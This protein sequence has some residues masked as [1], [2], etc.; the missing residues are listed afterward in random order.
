MTSLRL[1][2]VSETA[3]GMP[4]PSTTRWCLLPGLARSTGLGPLLG[5]A[6][7]PGRDWS[8]SP[9]GTSRSAWPPAASRAGARGAGPRRPPGSRLRAAASRSYPSRNPV[10][11]GGTPTGYRYA[12]RR[13]SRTGPAG[14]A[15]EAGPASASAPEPAATA[16]SATTVRPRRSTDETPSCPRN[17]PTSIQADSHTSGTSVSTSKSVPGPA[18]RP[19]PGAG[20]G[21]ALPQ[22][23]AACSGAELEIYPV[24]TLPLTNLLTRQDTVVG[25]PGAPCPRIAPRHR[26]RPRRPA[27]RR[28]RYLREPPRPGPRRQPA[29]PAPGALPAQETINGRGT[30]EGPGPAAMADAYALRVRRAAGRPESDTPTSPTAPPGRCP[31][32]PRCCCGQ[33]KSR[34]PGGGVEV[35][36][37]AALPPCCCADSQR[38]ISS[39]FQPLTGGHATP[40]SASWARVHAPLPVRAAS[41]S[42]GDGST[43]MWDQRMTGATVTRPRKSR[44]GPEFLSVRFRCPGLSGGGSRLPRCR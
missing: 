25:N 22:D 38:S 39:F 33:P 30:A 3:S 24:G 2:P 31:V 36:R 29:R 8:R 20:P 13:G 14:P 32:R 11:A 15:P 19:I 34:V 44:P 43:G 23:R 7:R 5:P 17:R 10:P 1:P 37:R 28:P 4:W 35:G 27:P 21:R 9:P 26:R 6:E 41:I 40:H 18:A 42:S 12:A 16:R